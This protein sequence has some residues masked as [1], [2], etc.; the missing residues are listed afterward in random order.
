MQC[1]G[2]TS[3]AGDW[4]RVAVADFDNLKAVS[5]ALDHS[6]LVWDM[7]N[8]GMHVAKLSGHSRAVT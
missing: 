4:C 6:L 8:L 7:R 5:A 3:E 2:S 1:L